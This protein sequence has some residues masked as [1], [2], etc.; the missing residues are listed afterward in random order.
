LTKFNIKVETRHSLLAKENLQGSRNASKFTAKKII[1]PAAS[2]D[3]AATR[4][5]TA[6]YKKIIEDN[7]FP[8][9]LAFNVDTGLY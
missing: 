1:G 9:D 5:F 4:A 3:T 2:A 7:D 8:P 6:E